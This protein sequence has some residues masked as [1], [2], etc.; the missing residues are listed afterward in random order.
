MLDTFADLCVHLH[1]N[2]NKTTLVNKKIAPILSHIE[3]SSVIFMMTCVNQSDSMTQLENTLSYASNIYENSCHDNGNT[4]KSQLL[5]NRSS[6][7][8]DTEYLR[9][10]I[11]KLTNEVNT[12]RYVRASVNTMMSA[13]NLSESNEPRHPSMFSSVSNSTTITVP[14]PIYEEKVAI[15]DLNRQI[16]ELEN[17]ISVTRERNI[18]VERELQQRTTSQDH[19]FSIQEK[20]NCIIEKLEWKLDDMERLNDQLYHKLLTET[21]NGALLNEQLNHE[22]TGLQRD[23]HLLKS[24][25]N[26]LDGVL[27]VMENMAYKNDKDT[28]NALLELTALKQLS[29]QQEE[30]I[31]MKDEE[32]ESLSYQLYNSNINTQRKLIKS[33]DLNDSANSSDIILNNDQR[34]MESRIEEFEEMVEHIRNQRDK[35]CDQLEERTDELEKLKENYITSENKGQELEKELKTVYLMVRENDTS[36]FVKKLEDEVET[37]QQ[38]KLADQID[39]QIIVNEMENM[40]SKMHKQLDDIQRLESTVGK[41]NQQLDETTS[42]YIQKEEDMLDLQDQLEMEKK[43]N[44]LTRL[45]RNISNADSHKSSSK[46]LPKRSDSLKH[47]SHNLPNQS[48]LSNWVQEKINDPNGRTADVIRTFLQISKENSRQATQIDELDKQLLELRY[49]LALTSKTSTKPSSSNLS[50]NGNRRKT[51]TGSTGSNSLLYSNLPNS[52]ESE[53]HLESIHSCGQSSRSMPNRQSGTTTPTFPPPCEPP[54]NPLP[55]VPML[56]YIPNNNSTCPSPSVHQ[57]LGSTQRESQLSEHTTT[58]EDGSI[59]PIDHYDYRPISLRL[60]SHVAGSQTSNEAVDMSFQLTALE[61]KIKEQER[62]IK[63]LSNDRAALKTV[64]N[65]LDMQALELENEKA[66]KMKAEKAH[67]ILERRMEEFMNAKKNKFRCF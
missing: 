59:A 66:L 34:A 51:K 39:F 6:Q 23:A 38:Q 15:S 55:P 29:Q 49:Q 36:G 8:D 54:C 1:T 31:K 20:Q 13:S 22:L 48:E 12:L 3:M 35:Y 45:E 64:T 24:R 7:N 18:H 57:Q 67:Y 65:Q 58:S 56:P 63:S 19:L 14:D 2:S 11:L 52:R 4:R 10:I 5:K 61:A 53:D 47:L 43:S 41:L 32:I 27:C 16:E 50:F 46:P 62:E 30:T 25:R 42:C 9:R 60:R 28:S 37:L 33:I 17:Q 40:S 44:E 26:E 21:E